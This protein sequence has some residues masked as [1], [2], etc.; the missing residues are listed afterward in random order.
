MTLK[1]FFDF[2]FTSFFPIFIKIIQQ[3]EL[4]SPQQSANIGM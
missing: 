1:D 3:I 4:I 2:L